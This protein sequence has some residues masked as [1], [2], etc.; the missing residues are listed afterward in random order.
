MVAGPREEQSSCA[1]TH[2][3]ISTHKDTENIERTRRE[4]RLPIGGISRWRRQG[5]LA[6][7]AEPS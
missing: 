7:R 3:R 4:F 1:S 2:A 5:Y 6:L